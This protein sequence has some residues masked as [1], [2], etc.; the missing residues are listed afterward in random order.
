[1]SNKFY[2][3]LRA[4]VTG[5]DIKHVYWINDRSFKY[6][7]HDEDD[8][9]DFVIVLHNCMSDYGLRCNYEYE[10]DVDGCEVTVEEC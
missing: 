9:A 3:A 7:F 5:Q 10:V 2:P 4:A 8:A 6:V 1:M